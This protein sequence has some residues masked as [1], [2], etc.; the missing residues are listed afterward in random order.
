MQKKNNNN[1]N[2]NKKTIII[3]CNCGH[4]TSTVQGH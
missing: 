4:K 3:N 1:N 2:Y